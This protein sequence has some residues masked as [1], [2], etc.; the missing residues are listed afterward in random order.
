MA[1]TD[2]S[3]ALIWFTWRN[4]LFKPS[5]TLAGWLNLGN[6]DAFLNLIFTANLKLGIPD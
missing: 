1:D 6:Q 2:Y 3:N 4:A 5:S